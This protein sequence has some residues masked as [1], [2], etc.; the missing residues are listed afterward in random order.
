M[1]AAGFAPNDV[2]HVFLSHIHLDHAGA[3]WRFAEL[4]ATIHV[5]PRGRASSD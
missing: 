1:R 5:H 3:A 2:R 4:G